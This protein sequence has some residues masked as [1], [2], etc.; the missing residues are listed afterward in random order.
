MNFIRTMID[1]TKRIKI[2]KKFLT[3]AILNKMASVL[4]IADRTNRTILQIM[5]IQPVKKNKMR[6]F[7][8]AKLMSINKLLCP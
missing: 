2:K 8:P 7:T 6:K 5:S 1:K 3:E 4:K